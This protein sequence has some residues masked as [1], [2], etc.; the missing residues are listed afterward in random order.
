MGSSPRFA[1]NPP[2]NLI[3]NDVLFSCSHTHHPNI[4]PGEY[5]MFQ[6]CELIK[7]SHNIRAV[8]ASS[9]AALGRSMSAAK[10]RKIKDKQLGSTVAV[11]LFS[12][13]PRA[14][15]TTNSDYGSKSPSNSPNV[16]DLPTSETNSNGYISGHGRQY[17]PSTSSHMKHHNKQQPLRP[18]PLTDVRLTFGAPGSSFRVPSL[19]DVLGGGDLSPFGGSRPLLVRTNSSNS[20]NH[21]HN[22]NAKGLRP[23]SSS[24][25]GSP[26]HRRSASGRAWRSPLSTQPKQGISSHESESGVEISHRR[27]LTNDESI[28]D[29]TGLHLSPLPFEDISAEIEQY[30]KIHN[31]NY[32]DNSAS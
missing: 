16:F 31:N 7:N 27:N 15:G 21:H 24:S 30:N 23:A 8:S 3:Y 22:N 10:L 11:D 19:A 29:L 1:C 5:N 12:P 17:T 13:S 14:E 26:G 9:T 28:H 20:S 18:K 2:N 4:S 32:N 25:H 6:S